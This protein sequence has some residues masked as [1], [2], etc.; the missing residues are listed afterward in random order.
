MTPSFDDFLNKKEKIAIVGLGY[1]GLPLAVHLAKPFD[2]IGIDTDK[3]RVAELE[4]GKD[5]TGEV[6]Q[7]DLAK[8]NIKFV[9]DPGIIKEARVVIVTVPTPIDQNKNPNLKPIKNAS[10]MI[11][12]NMSAGT[13]VVFE[14]TVYPGVTEEIC[15]PIMEEHSGL[16][17]GS[18]FTVGYSP[19]RI[20]PGDKEHSLATIVKVVAGQDEKTAELLSQIY[21]K[22]ITAGIHMAPDIRTAEAAKVIENIQRDLNIALMNELA[23]IFNQLGVD[24]NEVLRAANTKWNFLKFEPGLV[25]GHCIGVDPYYLTYKA[26][27][28]GY[29]P[30]VILSGR[31]VNDYMGKHVAEQTVKRLIQAGKP[32][33]GSKVLILGITFKENI[34]DIRNTKVVDII[35]ELTEYGID[36]Y[37]HDPYAIADEVK[38]VYDIK[39]IDDPDKFKPYDAIIFAVKHEKLLKY[40]LAALTGMAAEKPV[41][42]D[43]KSIFN[44]SDAENSGFIYWRL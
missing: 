24:T 6:G 13:V 35:N 10:R 32:V 9:S 21:G 15:V 43:V 2:V 38:A 11:G 33:K 12:E 41:L 18:D 19:E 27:E 39:M 14:S 3:L 22:V 20:N 5:R 44:K 34:K 42:V 4:N 29:Y 23:L 28:I 8:A 25:G 40:D 36:T 26:E 31:R 16:T 30:T 7:D 1:V 37:V 17:C